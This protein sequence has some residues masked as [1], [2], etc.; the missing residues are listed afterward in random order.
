MAQGQRLE[1][2]ARIG[3]IEKVG[4]GHGNDLKPLLWL[5]S[6]QTLLGQAQQALTEHS[7][8]CLVAL[9]QLAVA[10]PL[11]GLVPPGEDVGSQLAV[12]TLCLGLAGRHVG[13]LARFSQVDLIFT[14]KQIFEN[15]LFSRRRPIMVHPST[16]GI[17]NGTF[18][19]G[20]GKPGEGGCGSPTSMDD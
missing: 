13:T 12:H 11:P 20:L 15:M 2:A 4:G 16:R 9:A 10:E 17:G 6:Y 18:H 7:H 19:G 3:E 1:F 14:T 5:S 8:A